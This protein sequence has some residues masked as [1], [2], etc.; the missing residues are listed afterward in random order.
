LVAILLGLWAAHTPRGTSVRALQVARSKRSALSL[1][2]R[3]ARSNELRSILRVASVVVTAIVVSLAIAG[4][5]AGDYSSAELVRQALLWSGPVLAAAAAS[6]LIARPGFAALSDAAFEFQCQGEPLSWHDVVARAGCVED[7][8]IVSN[9]NALDDQLRTVGV[10]QDPLLPL[11]LAMVSCE[12]VKAVSATTVQLVIA[13]GSTVAD[14]TAGRIILD[15]ALIVRG[16]AAAA[17]VAP[18]SSPEFGLRFSTRS[19]WPRGVIARLL[20]GPPRTHEADSRPSPLLS[21]G[22]H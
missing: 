19:K 14:Y 13:Q 6:A 2:A 3:L 22:G 18:A 20:L 1:T 7:C 12:Q 9:A 17:A 10:G 16:K 11:A 15:R 21:A 4:A 5:R 8:P